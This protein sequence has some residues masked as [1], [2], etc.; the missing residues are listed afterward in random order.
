MVH[1]GSD[2]KLWAVSAAGIGSAAL[3]AYSIAGAL[4]TLVWNPLAAVPGA[5]LGEI[6]TAID[7]AGE[8]LGAPRMTDVTA[9]YLSLIV[10]A[11]PSHW[12]VAFTTALSGL[13]SPQSPSGAFSL[14][15][16]LCAAQAVRRCADSRSAGAHPC[17]R[18][19]YATETG[20]LSCSAGPRGARRRRSGGPAAGS[21]GHC[22]R[23]FQGWGCSSD[24]RTGRGPLPGTP[25]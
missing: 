2:P 22:P 16:R 19:M 4:Q 14:R 3:D 11:A 9:G 25:G 10:L 23:R 7:D 20:R 5:T 15:F 17:H 8:S 13:S 18:T 12:F 6:Y 24:Q 1:G 21:A